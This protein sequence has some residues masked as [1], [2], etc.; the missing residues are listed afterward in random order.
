VLKLGEDAKHL[1]H[2]LA[3]R[4]CGVDA[5]L[6][7][8]QVNA[9]GMDFREED[10]APGSLSTSRPMLKGRRKGNGIGRDA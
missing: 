8:E 3:A 7:Q 4:R 9:S 2:G 6:M 5:L 10:R 1:K